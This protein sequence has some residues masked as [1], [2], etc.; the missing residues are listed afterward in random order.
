MVDKQHILVYGIGN[1]LLTD[2]GIGPKLIMKLQKTHPHKNLIYETA[3][4]G[5]LDILDMISGYSMVVFLDAIKT[6]GG[7][8]GTIYLFSPDDFKETLHL[9]NLHDIKFLTAIEL[10]KQ[11]NYKIPPNIVIIAIEIIEDSVYSEKFS[12]EIELLFPKI[13]KKIGDYLIDQTKCK[14]TIPELKI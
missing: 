7:I 12:P 10:G 3:F 1:E 14:D 6:R 4:V 8:P 9:S 5:G 2:D 13:L 11:L